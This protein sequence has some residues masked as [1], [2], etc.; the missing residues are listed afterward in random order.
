CNGRMRRPGSVPGPKASR[1]SSHRRPQPSSR[2]AR[3]AL[4]VLCTTLLILVL[5]VP[6]SAQPRQPDRFEF[7][8]YDKWDRPLQGLVIALDPRHNGGNS[9]AADVINQRISDGRGGWH[10]CDS[11]GNTTR[12]GY[13]A[14]ELTF[15]VAE[16]LAD[17]L[18]HLG[19]EVRSTRTNDVGAG[20]CVDVRGRFAEDNDADLM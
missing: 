13:P 8:E 11:V 1:M 5:A 15:D 20:P 12:G 3:S 9:D 2:T 14:H 7:G 10:V 18:E 6:A 16:R 19:A 17:E 4:G